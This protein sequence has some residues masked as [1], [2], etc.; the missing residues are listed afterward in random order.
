[1]TRFSIRRTHASGGS[2]G[3]IARVI[4][5]ET[6]KMKKILLISWG[7][8]LIGLIGL[9]LHPDLPHG[10]SGHLQGYGDDRRI[11]RRNPYDPPIYHSQK[12]EDIEMERYR[13]Q[14]PFFSFFN[15][16]F[17]LGLIVSLLLSAYA[18]CRAVVRFLTVSLLLL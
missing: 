15:N 9:L 7:V 6:H 12:A 5:I 11:K 13:Q 2:S 17:W 16:T 18:I 3:T 1:M 4:T 10:Y 8:T 14:Y